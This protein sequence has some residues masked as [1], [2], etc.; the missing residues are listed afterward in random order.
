LWFS[1]PLPRD[2]LQYAADDVRYL[3]PI[4]HS[5]LQTLPAVTLQLSTIN[6]QLGQSRELR[7]QRGL[8]PGY[9]PLLRSTA[10][11]HQHS[12]AGSAGSAEHGVMEY[13]G[14]T[15]L[16]FELT[17]DESVPGWFQASYKVYLNEQETADA[18]NSSSAAAAA[19]VSALSAQAAELAGVY[20]SS[21]YLQ[22]MPDRAPAGPE[23]E[24]AG[25]DEDGSNGA[26][27]R[28][29]SS[30]GGGSAGANVSAMLCLS[31]SRAYCMPGHQHHQQR[32]Q[33]P[34]SLV[35][36]QQKGRCC[37][38]AQCAGW[39]EAAMMMI[40]GLMQQALIMLCTA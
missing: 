9:V 4:A 17:L 36:A 30:S 28:G 29:S 21:A 3:L 38:T 1:H 37:K 34:C 24:Q 31:A 14:L 23:E 15:D 25:R 33:T 22:R 12:R 26:D 6:M 32:I 27:A 10:G 20:G 35:T 39:R 7:L 13:P 11:S 2:A 40:G 8:L 18:G 19:A 5:L 16:Q